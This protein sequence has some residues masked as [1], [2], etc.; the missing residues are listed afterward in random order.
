MAFARSSRLSTSSARNAWRAVMSKAFTKPRKRLKRRICQTAMT[1][2]RASTASRKACAIARLWVRSKSRCRFQRSTN[3]PAS[4]VRNK[5]GICPKNPATPNQKP[6]WVKRN[7]SQATA[8]CC[9]QVPIRD[10]LWPTKNNR[11]LRCA[12]ARRNNFRFM[13]ARPSCWGPRCLH[14][15]ARPGLRTAP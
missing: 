3:T 7:T 11:K 9:I 10:R 8:S 2:L 4:G 12:K 14:R 1:P 6:E 5:V 15:S 13:G